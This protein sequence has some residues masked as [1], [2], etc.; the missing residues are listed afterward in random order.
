MSENTCFCNLCSL[1]S[2]CLLRGL[3]D[4]LFGYAPSF[5]STPKIPSALNAAID[6]IFA[7][8]CAGSNARFVT[9][10]LQP[11]Q[12]ASGRS[13]HRCLLANGDASI[14]ATA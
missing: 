13:Y 9:G 3:F 1:K 4:E 5:L 12:I 2:F 8:V 11:P 14:E 10:T 6:Y 7:T